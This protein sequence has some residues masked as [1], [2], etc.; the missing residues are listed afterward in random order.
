MRIQTTTR[1]ITCILVPLAVLATVSTLLQRHFHEEQMRAHEVEKEAL[2][3][4]DQLRAGSD[5]LTGAVRAYAATGDQKFR[6]EFQQ[7]VTVDR[8]RDKALE[9]LKELGLP[10]KELALVERAKRNSDKLI[11]LEDRA[12]AAAATNDLKTAVALVHGEEYRLAKASIMEPL[13]D[14]RHQLEGRLQLEVQ[15]KRTIARMF[16][17]L[18]LISVTS[19][20][21]AMLAALG[22]FFRK[23]VTPLAGLKRDIDQLLAGKKDV[24]VGFQTEATEV[25]DIARSLESYRKS[26]DEVERQR[27][28]KAQLTQI[29]NELQ[30]A[31]SFAQFGSRLLSKLVPLAGGGLGAMYR[32]NPATE[33]LELVAGYGLDSAAEARHSLKWG[34]G[35]IGQCAVEQKAITLRNLP[36]EYTQ[37]SSGLGAAPPSLLR[38]APILSQDRVLGVLELAS[39]SEWTETQAALLDE[40]TAVVALNLEILSRNLRTEE[41]LGQT[42]EQARQ[43]EEQTEE[44]TQSQEELLAQKREL[45]TNESSSRSARSARDSFSNPAARAFLARTPKDG[46]PS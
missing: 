27:W 4:A 29:S 21:L 26:A 32:L 24:Y 1:T 2:L 34:E 40:V 23:V 30:V 11:N 33:T 5:R 44:L 35:L 13:Q 10:P 9:K 42:Q 18:A 46:L 7:E 39:F 41:L 36:P 12:F 25:G 38:I 19:S 28:I 31:E 14:F 3:A 20:A 37:L 6:D 45:T 15:H 22:F 43:L 8:S 17:L 16:A